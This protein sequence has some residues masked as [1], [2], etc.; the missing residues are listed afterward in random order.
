[1]GGAKLEVLTFD[2]IIDIPYYKGV[3]REAPGFVLTRINILGFD[4]PQYLGAIYIMQLFTMIIMFH[5]CNLFC[6]SPTLI[7]IKENKDI[8]S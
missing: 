7:V 8:G 1:M 3:C 5:V 2:P 6:F 4:F